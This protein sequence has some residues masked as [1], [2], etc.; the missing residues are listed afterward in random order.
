M[1]SIIKLVVVYCRRFPETM[2]VIVTA[3]VRENSEKFDLVAIV[4]TMVTGAWQWGFY[5]RTA[6]DCQYIYSGALSNRQH[7]HEPPQ[8]LLAM[9]T[10][11]PRILPHFL[12]QTIRDPPESTESPIAP[13]ATNLS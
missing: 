12:A 9:V 7:R 2:A 1:E 6:L 11:A 13:R 8:K 5:L 10:L 4:P 3:E